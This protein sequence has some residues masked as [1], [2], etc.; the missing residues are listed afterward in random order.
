MVVIVED[1]E[2]ASSADWPDV[3]ISSQSYAGNYAGYHSSSGPSDAKTSGPFPVAGDTFN[4][5]LKESSNN[6]KGLIWAYDTSS[7]EFYML[8]QTGSNAYIYY[9]DGSSYNNIG[10]TASSLP[11]V[12]DW[13]NFIVD[14]GTDGSLNCEITDGT[15]SDTVSATSTTL[16]NGSVAV[17]GLI[18]FDEFIITAGPSVGGP[19][20]QSAAI[21][22]VFPTLSAIAPTVDVGVISGN[23]GMSTL[24]ITAHPVTVGTGVISGNLGVSTLGI[25]APSVSATSV[26]S[27]G[28]TTLT[29][30]SGE[31]DAGSTK[32]DW[33]D[34]NVPNLGWVYDNYDFA[35]DPRPDMTQFTGSYT[36]ESANS[37][38]YFNGP[39]MGNGFVFNGLTHG[40]GIYRADVEPDTGSP[41]VVYG[42]QDSNNFYFFRNG[43][44]DYQFYV[45]SGGTFTLVWSGGTPPSRGIVEVRVTG[46]G[47]P[48]VSHELYV[49][50]TFL[51]TLTT[52]DSGLLDNHGPGQFGCRSYSK[53]YI[54]STEAR[55]PSS[56]SF[57]LA[58]KST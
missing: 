29:W 18:S 46:L 57:S 15:T 31:Y 49:D 47:T 26:L 21:S 52:S 33:T 5:W 40:D 35:V 37:R 45:K 17:Y 1:F 41:G 19:S 58:A 8:Y 43:G 23:L 10:G 39:T 6:V 12:G 4:C 22:A 14:W 25:T 48:S 54:Y 11:T 24:G 27:G 42:Y 30:A 20:S 34:Q 44:S 16:T 56:G 50:G 9:F 38:M 51:K 53:G 32:I 3:E 13:G 2:D 7:V 36:F 28:S 55:H